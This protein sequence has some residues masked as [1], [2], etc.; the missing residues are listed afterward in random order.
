MPGS[1]A[2]ETFPVFAVTGVEILHSTSQ[3]KI[4]VVVVRGLTSSEGWEDG[5]LVPTGSGI[6]PDGVLDLILVAQSPAASATPTG[7]MPIHAV[8]PLTADH[9]FKAVRVRGATNA[10]LL[11][12]LHG[13][14]EVKAP[15]E[16]CNHC[17]G[18]YFVAKGGT[19]PSGMAADRIVAR[20][21]CPVLRES[22]VPMK[23]LAACTGIPTG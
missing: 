3:P 14:V 13:L 16:L 1:Q 17:V 10:V 15:T 2:G 9:P 11:Q 4:S 23:A 8:L 19:A 6:P 20:T 12:D 21:I 5:E 18:R 7:Y 22:F